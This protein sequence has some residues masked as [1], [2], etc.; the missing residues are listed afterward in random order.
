MRAAALLSLLA[1]VAAA[2][3][4][5]SGF[6]VG[7]LRRDGVVI[8]F[9]MYDGNRWSPNWPPAARDPEIPINLRSVPARW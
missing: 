1:V 7:V 9:A 5:P 3:A 8:P 4:E 6:T 2:A